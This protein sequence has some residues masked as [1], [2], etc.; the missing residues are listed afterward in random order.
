MKKT[1]LI[2]F[3]FI[4]VV[5]FSCL[6]GCENAYKNMKLT[7]SKTEVEIELKNNT[8]VE[9]VKVVAT[10]GGVDKKISKSVSVSTQSNCVSVACVE[11]EDKTTEIFITPIS[12]IP[13]NTAVITVKTVEGNKTA[14]ITVKVIKKPTEMTYNENY[15]PAIALNTQLQLNGSLA[16]NFGENDADATE[17]DVVFSLKQLSEFIFFFW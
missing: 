7:L 13:E 17:K 15:K 9:P 16:V 5:S 12:T 11:Q 4:L 8:E 10:V 1:I 14:S 6:L 2:L 3:S